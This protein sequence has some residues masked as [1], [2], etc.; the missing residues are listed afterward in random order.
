MF[1]QLSSCLLF[2]AIAT[3]YINAQILSEFE[4]NPAGGDPAETTF[5]LSGGTAGDA[6][7]LWILSIENDGLNGNVDRAANVMGSFDANGFA[8][9][10]VPDLENP[11][12]TVVLTD[13]FTGMI[14][15][16]LDPADDGVLD[17]STLGTVLD[18]VG[19]SDSENDDATLY[20]GTLGGS[21]I[22][23]NGQFEPLR[24]FR[25]TTT[26]D[27]FQTVTVDFGQDT[28]HIGLFAAGGGDELD[29]GTFPVDPFVTSYGAPNTVPEPAG[30]ALLL[31]SILGLVARRRS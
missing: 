22:L 4:P 17:L 29:A 2:V 5:E 26:S 25:D 8:V 31:L 7:D 10:N 11:S 19:V 13:S 28:E 23:Y 21:N 3:S 9:V 12:F 15:T 1:R 14:G 24:V 30:A 20:G 16:D 18:A 6:F 27:W